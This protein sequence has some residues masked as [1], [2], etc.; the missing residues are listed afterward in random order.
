MFK[1]NFYFKKPTLKK[2]YFKKTSFSKKL[3]VRVNSCDN[4]RPGIPVIAMCVWGMLLMKN[5]APNPYPLATDRYVHFRYVHFIAMDIS[6][7]ALDISE[8]KVLFLFRYI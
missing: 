7:I 5:I 3:G 1:K 4:V 2:I 6:E 8:I